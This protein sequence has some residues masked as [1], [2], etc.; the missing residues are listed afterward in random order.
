MTTAA[1]HAPF[2]RPPRRAARLR[3]NSPTRRTWPLLAGLTALWL[4]GC[5]D[6]ISVEPAVEPQPAAPAKPLL[7]P[8]TTSA[9]E[10]PL[11]QAVAE[12]SHALHLRKL[13]YDG[14]PKKRRDCSGIFHEAMQ[15]LQQRCPGLLSPRF[16]EA[17]SSA[18][19]HDWYRDQGA[20]QTVREPLASTELLRPGAVLFYKNSQEDRASHMGI[21]VDLQHQV[22]GSLI[23]YRLF[24]GRRP[25]RPAAI[26]QHLVKPRTDEPLGVGNKAWFAASHLCPGASCRCSAAGEGALRDTDGL[27]VA[28]NDPQGDAH[29]LLINKPAATPASSDS[30]DAKPPTQGIASYYHPSLNGNITASGERY[31]DSALTAAHRILPFDT[32]VRV[33]RVDDGRSVVVRV[34]DR[35]PY[36]P[37]RII[38]VSGAAARELGMQL[39]GLVEVR[40]ERVE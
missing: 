24:H 32:R 18:S 1:F 9:L 25:G 19:I 11:A 12:V 6:K 5:S 16:D 3:P 39:D 33:V 2:S 23:G 40:I 22:D 4:S 10:V 14:D 36:A 13:A 17:R 29:E 37:N 8:N 7:E 20:L 35:G 28:S 34:N 31:D 26:T 15:Q 38:D 30:A 21:V 27:L